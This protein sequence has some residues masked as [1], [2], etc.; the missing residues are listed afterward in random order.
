M[1]VRADVLCAQGRV[2]ERSRA[3]LDARGLACM[4]LG[5]VERLTRGGSVGGVGGS[6]RVWRLFD[7]L[8]MLPVNGEP[9][10]CP[11][12]RLDVGRHL[13]T[14]ARE[15]GGELRGDRLANVERGR[16][17]AALQLRRAV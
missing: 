13:E 11:E 17:Q 10:V 1:G 8:G 2:R 5:F 4:H 15:V 6:L 12:R 7:R 16:E 9:L 3:M 14:F